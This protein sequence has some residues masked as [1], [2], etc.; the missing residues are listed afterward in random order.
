MQSVISRHPAEPV[1]L[2]GATSTGRSLPEAAVC[3]PRAVAQ[4]PALLTGTP[5]GQQRQQR[6]A[7]HPPPPDT[8]WTWLF[9][10]FK[11]ACAPTAHALHNELE[12]EVLLGCVWK[13]LR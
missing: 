2:L 4:A 8:Q 12:R 10:L 13:R 11:F 3:A 6:R 1:P 5:S 9:Q 7:F